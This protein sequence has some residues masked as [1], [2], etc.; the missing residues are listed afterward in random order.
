MG[1]E[2][3]KRNFSMR[4]FLIHTD[5]I[6]G[7][8]LEYIHHLYMGALL[9]PE[10]DFVFVLPQRFEK[11]SI[12]LN[13]PKSS[14]VKL[15]VLQA[16]EEAPHNCNLLKKGWKNSKVLAKYAKQYKVSDIVTISLI[17]YLPFLPLFIRNVRVRGIIYRIYLYEWKDETLC[18]KI[19]DAMKY[20]IMSRFKVFFRVYM[21]NDSASAQCLNRIFKTDKYRFMPDPV[22][23]LQNY[24]GKDIREELGISSSKIVLLHPG[25]MDSYKNT[26]GI[27]RSLLLLDKTCSDK[28]S[29][30]LAGR[31]VPGIRK[32]FDELYKKVSQKIQ[33]IF[34]EGYLPF[35]KL[36]DLFVTCDYVLVPYTV[37]SQSSGIVGHAA[38]YGKPVVAVQ[39]GVIGKMVRRWHLGK[40]LYKSS[41][42]SIYQ[43]LSG[44]IDKPSFST[45]GN[46]YLES[47]S[48]EMFC[49]VLMSE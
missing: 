6:G 38:Y 34:L 46:S 19:Q 26:L 9:R 23:S 32:E 39:G 1:E 44:V 35:E 21:C 7:H 47:H 22:A 43:F 24:K 33:I 4:T 45:A 11:D 3:N 13:W 30:I 28:F 37:K 18:M 16:N 49:H 36:A 29:V 25:G 12:R 31:V 20:L 41:K 10:D 42:E 17:T 15:I 5:S 14:N 48:V 8:Q 2:I 40:L 27:L